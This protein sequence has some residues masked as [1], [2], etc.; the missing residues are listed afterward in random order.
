[1]NT[2]PRSVLR[3]LKLRATHYSEVHA[4]MVQTG[5]TIS[6]PT[7]SHEPLKG[8]RVFMAQWVVTVL[9]ETFLS[10]YPGAERLVQ[11]R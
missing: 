3:G 11:L 10:L 4:G 9:G 1:M 6:Q 5:A 2:D 8:M 7:G